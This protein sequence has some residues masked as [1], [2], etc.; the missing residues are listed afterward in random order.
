MTHVGVDQPSFDAVCALL[1]ELAELRESLRGSG[2]GP[3][4]GPSETLYRESDLVRVDV[5]LVSAAPAAVI[6]LQCQPTQLLLD[7]VSALRAR[8]AQHDALDHG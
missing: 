3:L 5:E 7:L 6:K 8:K 2:A 4:E 1:E